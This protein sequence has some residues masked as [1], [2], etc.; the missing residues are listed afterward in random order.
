MSALSGT[1]AAMVTPFLQ[2][3]EGAEAAQA[4][5]SLVPRLAPVMSKMRFL[6]ASVSTTTYDPSTRSFR[7]HKIVRTKGPKPASP[8]AEKKAPEKAEPTK[9]ADL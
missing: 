4:I 6:E 8:P 5:L 2:G 3:Q 9:E 7:Q 1:I